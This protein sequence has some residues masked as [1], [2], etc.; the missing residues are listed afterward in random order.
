M[1]LFSKKQAKSSS[2]IAAAAPAAPPEP[3]VI[4]PTFD[5]PEDNAR[6]EMA[7]TYAATLTKLAATYQECFKMAHDIDWMC[8]LG[9]GA[10]SPN[11][12]PVDAATRQLMGQFAEE[13]KR[14]LPTLLARLREE[15]RGAEA[16]RNDTAVLFGYDDTGTS[17]FPDWC[18]AHGVSSSVLE[19][20]AENHI[21]LNTDFGLTWGSFCQENGRLIA[22]QESA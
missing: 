18:E 5:D 12:T 2:A 19:A 3:P 22:A 1:G 11:G 20:V 7:H 8:A 17:T 6:W 15:T 10:A 14:A 21:Y 9:Q 4:V 13:K 16:R